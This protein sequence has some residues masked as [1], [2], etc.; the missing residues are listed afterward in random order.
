MEHSRSRTRSHSPHLHDNAYFSPKRVQKS[1][2]HIACKSSKHTF[3]NARSS[4]KSSHKSKYSHSP[5]RNVRTR[6]KTLSP[7]KDS[8]INIKNSDTSESTSK[9]RKSTKTSPPD[10]YN[11]KVKLS[12]TS[13]FSELVKDRQMRNLAMK[14]L[15]NINNEVVE[16]HDD[17]DNEKT[18]E[19]D[20]KINISENKIERS[21]FEN[22][23]EVPKILDNKIEHSIITVTPSDTKRDV[24]KTVLPLPPKYPDNNQISSNSEIKCS[25]KSIKELPFP[26]GKL[27]FYF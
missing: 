10:H 19:N 15:T 27:N 6:S 2:T 20:S 25:K 7:V 18:V 3:H 26:P 17:S 12:D 16:I 4:K 23:T 11:S 24:S 14:C 22:D 1:P 21:K 13:L 8:R 9:K 5:S